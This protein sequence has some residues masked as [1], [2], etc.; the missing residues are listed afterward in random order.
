M[1][2]HDVPRE[3]EAVKVFAI[4]HYSTCTDECDEKTNT[5]TPSARGNRTQTKAHV[6]CGARFQRN[7]RK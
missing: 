7:Q 4:E 5:F 2:R 6:G 3:G 1:M